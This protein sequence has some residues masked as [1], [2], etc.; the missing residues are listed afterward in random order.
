MLKTTIFC[1]GLCPSFVPTKKK[2]F[3]VVIKLEITLSWKCTQVICIPEKTIITTWVNHALRSIFFF[4]QK[5][6]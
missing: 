2:P 1:M 4:S 6:E 3:F 5:E